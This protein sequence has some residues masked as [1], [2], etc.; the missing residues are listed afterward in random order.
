MATDRMR[1]GGERRGVGAWFRKANDPAA[2][3]GP[4]TRGRTARPPYAFTPD[5][6]RLVA[7]RR[8]VAARL[9]PVC[10]DMP[11]EAFELLV[12]DVAAFRLRWAPR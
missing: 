3:P 12:R 6:P 5:D 4:V 8:E 2:A 11:A 1:R 9:R 7:L 10:A